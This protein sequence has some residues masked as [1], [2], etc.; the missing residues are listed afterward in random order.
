MT[1]REICQDYQD[2]YDYIG[3]TP[4][5]SRET[6]RVINLVDEIMLKQMC[7]RYNIETN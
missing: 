5:P 6:A 7:R 4:L 1:G 2:M 3:Y